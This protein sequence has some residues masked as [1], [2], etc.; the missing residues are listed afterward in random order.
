MHLT[1]FFITYL[2]TYLLIFLLFLFMAS[3]KYSLEQQM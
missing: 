3:A 2:L 1:Y